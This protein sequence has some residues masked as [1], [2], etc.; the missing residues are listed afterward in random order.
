MACSSLTLLTRPAQAGGEAGERAVRSAVGQQEPAA[1]TVVDQ[2][3]TDREPQIGHVPPDQRMAAGQVDALGGAGDRLDGISRAGGSA[4]QVDD[5]RA[6]RGRLGVSAQH[7]DLGPQSST[8]APS[9]RRSAALAMAPTNLKTEGM[10]AILLAGG[11]APQSAAWT[12]DALLLYVA[13]YCLVA[14]I[15]RRRSADDDA[16]WAVDRDELLRHFSALPADTFPRITRHAGEPTAGEG[17]DRWDLR[18]R[19]G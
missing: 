12:I 4:Q 14:S 13:A 3:G 17:H 9:G 10:L 7:P 6:Q 2:L 15:V 1:V 5:D 16:V 19:T 8:Q 18:T 11:V